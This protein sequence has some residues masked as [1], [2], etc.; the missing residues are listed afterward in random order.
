[1]HEPEFESEPPLVFELTE[2]DPVGVDT[3][4]VSVSETVAVQVVALPTD[5]EAGVQ[6]TEVPVLRVLTV[7]VVEPLLVA[8]AESPP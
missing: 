3:F 4:P 6:D 2:T 1:M 5:T 8:C 7:T